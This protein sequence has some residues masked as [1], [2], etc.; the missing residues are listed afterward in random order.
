MTSRF[1]DPD[2][3]DNRSLKAAVSQRVKAFFVMNNTR[4]YADKRFYFLGAMA[5]SALVLGFALPDDKTPPPAA[6]AM[7]SVLPSFDLTRDDLFLEEGRF[8]ALSETHLTLKSGQNLGP[9][10]QQNGVSPQTA[11]KVTQAFGSVFDPRKLRA[12][13]NFALSFDGDTLTD[14]TF[15]PN[16]DTTVFVSRGDGDNFSAR[17]LTAELKFDRMRVSGTIENSLYLDASRL[18]A[19]DKV[20]QQFANIYE[21]SVDFQRDIRK[22]D[23]FELFFEVSRDHNGKVV[24]ARNLL[25][26]SFSPRGRTMDYYLFEDDKGRENFYDADGKTAKRKL[27]AT[28]VN[29]ARLSSTYGKR[30]HPVLGYRKMHKGVDFAAPRGTPIMAAGNGTVER[31][32]RF[33][34]FGNYIKIRH[35]DG[36][37]TAYAHLKGF[38]RGIKAGAY[39]TQ[40]QIIGYVGTT[41]RSTGPHLHYE[42]HKNGRAINPRTL[43]Q[44]SGKPIAKKDRP[45]FD[46]RRK[47]VDAMRADYA[48]ADLVAEAA[49]I[50]LPA[51]Y[52]VLAAPN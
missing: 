28:P 16:V 40:D 14:L 37:Q 27:R 49:P 1:P 38:A 12:G 11:Y 23:A 19:P 2:L 48:K 50:A 22:G 32:N 43:N 6:N 46:A 47:A 51:G 36:Y 24:K 10:L 8:D 21:Y 4:I 35:S 18:G 33:G 42:V 3:P 34:S 29:G 26:T 39:V 13:Q 9:L 45:A 30:R 25:F 52:G 44:L 20:I 31:A 5:A 17:Q 41:G 15:K 7:A